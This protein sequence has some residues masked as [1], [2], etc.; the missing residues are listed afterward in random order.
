M[1]ENIKIKINIGKK[2]VK[3]R[4]INIIWSIFE[5]VIYLTNTSLIINQIIISLIRHCLDRAFAGKTFAPKKFLAIYFYIGF[6]QKCDRLFP[7][8]DINR[9]IWSDLWKRK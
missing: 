1:L 5:T 7:F 2:M 9:I 8:L 6:I 4:E 3:S